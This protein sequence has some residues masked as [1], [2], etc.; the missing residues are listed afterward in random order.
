[1]ADNFFVTAVVVAHDGSTWL[2]EAI[3]ALTSQ[4]RPIDRILAVDTGS[5]DNSAKLLA[6]AGIKVIKADREI[7]F[8]DAIDL[9]LADTPAISDSENELLWILHDDCAPSRN[10]LE[11]LIAE[12]VDQPQVACVGPKIRNWYDRQQLLEVGISI[13]GN[14]ARWTGLESNEQDQGQYDQPRQVLAVSTAAMLVRRDVFA[15]V[16]GLDPNLALFRDDVDFGWRVRVAG[17]TVKC[18]PAATLFHAEA[19]SMERRAIDVSEAFLHRPLLLDRRNAAYVLLVNSSWWML[20]WLVIQLFGT[21]VIRSIGDILAKLPGYASDEIVAVGYL[22]VKPKDIF[23]GRRL[24][25]QKRLLSAQVVKPFIPPRGE[26][27]RAGWE[28]LT[29]GI[30][31]LI[32][33]RDVEPERDLFD[34]T[35]QTYSD[36]GTIDENFDEL[37]LSQPAKASR[38]KTLSNRPLL[39][40]LAALTLLTTVASRNRFGNLSGGALAFSPSGSMDLLGHYADSWHSVGLGSSAPTP[41]WLAVTGLLSLL[42]FGNLPFFVALLF[43][44]TP[45][46]ALFV[47]YRSL[48]RYGLTPA[49]AVLGGVLYSLSPVIWNSVNQGRIGTIAI[50]L[51][52]PTFLSLAPL[53]RAEDNES[54][55]RIYGLA[56][57]ASV[58]AS[59]SAA[60]LVIWTVVV[61]SY[62]VRSLLARRSEISELSPVTFLM[63]ARLDAEKRYFAYLIIPWILTLPWCVT[64]LVHPTQFLQDPGFPIN[65]PHPWLAALLTSGVASSIWWWVI[66][67]FVIFAGYTLVHRESRKVGF[68]A[69]LL[70][71][72]IVALSTLHISGHGSTGSFWSGSIMIVIEALV[73]PPTLVTATSLTKNLKESALGLGHILSAVTVAIALF[74]IVTTTTWTLTDGGNSLVKNNRNSVIPAFI[75]SLAD[76]PARPKTL[77]I[78]SKGA[79]DTAYFVSRG[80]DLQLGDPDVVVALPPVLDDSIRGLVTGTLPT[81]GPVI[82][83]FGIQYVFLTNPV[84]EAIARRI[85]GVGGFARTSATSNGIVWK[86]NAGLPRVSEVNA[87]NQRTPLNSGDIGS[88]DTLVQPGTIDVTEKFDSSWHLLVGGTGVHATQTPNG[89]TEFVTTS[90][91]P[92][93]LLNDGTSRRALLSLELIA[94]LTVTVLALPAGRR[95]RDIAAGKAE[96]VGGAE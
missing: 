75:A 84:D 38:W 64:L 85:D 81:V 32:L 12:M 70:Y 8:G 18:V 28:R 20:P 39:V 71:G 1:V 37:D 31:A 33:R 47:M 2:T 30:G 11:A 92:M 51:L 94:L 14:G 25:K 59:F 48:K 56:L 78:T 63:T 91:G 22:L 13:A 79:G 45:P 9:A 6:G 74:S 41:P 21:A 65:D 3:A 50:A 42:T 5:I 53:R 19:S 43:W 40:A 57:F 29:E 95:R 67:P 16:G 77:V 58:L 66:S 60:L 4:T 10:A 61:A 7:G 17:F 55:R 82:G 72:L 27:L 54:W 83:S 35:A 93:T 24:R 23:V 15:E 26:Q 44:I 52:I 34:E 76:V 46:L 96:K 88:R 89:L 86:V 69:A 80:N 36:L 49:T 68:V 73:L 90:T 62:L 87:L